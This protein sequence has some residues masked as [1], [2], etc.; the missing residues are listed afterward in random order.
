MAQTIKLKRSATAGAIPSTSDLALGEIAIN[1]AD[2]AVYIKKGNDDIVAVHDNDILHIDTSNSRVGIGTTSPSAKLHVFTAGHFK[3]DTGSSPIV[4]IANNSATSSTSGTATL[5]FTQANTQAGGKIVSGR[6][7]DYSNG[8]TRQT[9]MA[10]YTATTASDT[11]KMRIT[12]TGNVGIGESSPDGKLHIKG[13]TASGD[14]S[15]ILFENTQGNK[16][17]S[18]GGGA[19]GI[20]NDNLHIRNVT[21]NTVLM[22]IMQ[23]G[24]VGINTTSPQQKLHVEGEVRADRFRVDGT[25]SILKKQVDSWTSGVQ[26]HDILYNGWTSST[27]DYTYVKAAGNGAAGHGILQV[28]DLGTWIGQTDLEIGALADS[29]T[30]PIDNVFAFF[31]G[32]TSYIKGNLAIGNTNPSAKLDIR[33]DSGYA[34]RAENGS[35]Q[36]FRIAAGGATEV[37]GLITANAGVKVPDSQE[38]NLGTASD[39]RL[40]HNG[41]DSHIL[42]NTGDLYISNN[43]D[44]KD[45]IFRSDDGSGGMANYLTI[46]GNAGLTKFNKNTKHLDNIKATFGDSGD[47]EIYHDGSN[48]IINDNGTGTIRIQTGGSNQWEFNGVNFKGNDGRKIILGDSSDLQIYHNGSDSYIQ[49]TGTGVLAILSNETRIQNSAGTENCAKFTENGAVTLFYDNNPRLATSSTGTDFTGNVTVN[50]NSASTSYGNHDAALR[51]DNTNATANNWASL[52]FDSNNGASADIS[53]KYTDHTNNYADLYFSNRGS[54]GYTTKMIILQ[55]G[56]VGINTT[57]PSEKLQV[58]GNIALNGEL[59]LVTAIRHANS[60][61]QVIDNDN[62]TYFIIN[63][64]EG[65]NRIKIGDSGDRTTTIRNNTLRFESADG[66][67]GMMMDSNRNF[68]VGATSYAGNSSSVTGSGLSDGY[69][70]ASRSSNEAAIFNRLSTDGEVVLIRKNGSDVGEIGTYNSDLHIGT[71]DT[72]I[73]FNNASR[74]IVPMDPSTPD[75]AGSLISLGTSSVKFK[76]LHL[77]GTANV[78]TIAS[79]GSM[80][81]DVGGNLTIDVDGTTIVLNDGGLNWGQMFSTGAGAFNIYSPQSNQDILFRGNDGGSNIIALTL[82]M[83][84]AGKAT[85]NSDVVVGGDLTVQGTTTTLNTATLDVEDK[86]I[87]LN[88]GSGDTSASANGAGI[89]IQDAV[90]ASN[91]AT[92]LWNSSSDGFEFSHDVNIAGMVTATGNNHTFYSG[93]G[94]ST[95]SFGR[96]QHERLQIYVQDSTVTLTADQDSDGNG[97]H[98]FVLDRTFDGTGANNFRIRKGGKEQLVINSSGH[99][100][101]GYYQCGSNTVCRISCIFRW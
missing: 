71:G 16:V 56:N 60:G 27:G 28:G 7:G 42:N 17:F 72:G 96:N 13:G 19:N 3:V 26:I 80:T 30:A 47:L 37:A 50:V 66:S 87:T 92:I 34:F 36:Y 32:D 6:D 23:G 79:T 74:S 24:N 86:N 84:N 82:D 95:A 49:D 20:T 59:K 62:D 89:T 68:I 25:G 31:R 5:K 21:D 94:S 90:D 64:P 98:D 53:A 63:D 43:A 93:A 54:G 88:Y 38:V 61:A 76:D 8:S 77:S 12:A 33:M 67:L 22:S 52:V 99:L 18:I 69:M 97:Q 83:S 29:N 1:T 4:E 9:H 73:G 41:T 101:S 70:W 40:L 45:V 75:F 85:F 39:V 2:G 10:F 81:L 100:I 57:N 35:G 91:D 46:D 44:D 14:L 48:S 11:E 78:D 65:S 55:S 51:I 58:D 15:H